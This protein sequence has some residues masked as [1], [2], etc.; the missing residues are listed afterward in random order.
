MR[1]RLTIITLP[2]LALW[3]CGTAPTPAEPPRCGATIDHKAVTVVDA[4]HLDARQD[5]GFAADYAAQEI[6]EFELLTPLTFRTDSWPTIG[7]SWAHSQRQAAKQGCNV[8]I[9]V[10]SEMFVGDADH[11]TRHWYYLLGSQAD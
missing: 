6:G 10:D 2:L 9:L 8:M 4:T 11:P 5:A 1:I 3:G 7:P